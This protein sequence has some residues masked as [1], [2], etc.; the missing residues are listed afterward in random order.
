MVKLT[1][2]RS[3]SR[4]PPLEIEPQSRNLTPIILRT[5]NHLALTL[6]FIGFIFTSVAKV[7]LF[8]IN[9]YNK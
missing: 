3:T 6:N 5:T 9:S 7:S 4:D 2:S 8:I 1:C